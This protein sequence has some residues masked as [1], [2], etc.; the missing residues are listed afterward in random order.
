MIIDTHKDNLDYSRLNIYPDDFVSESKKQKSTWMKTTMD[1][2]ENVAL[3]QFNKNKKSI[4]NNYDLL[5]G[6]LKPQDFYMED[7]MEISSFMDQIVG[8]EGLPSHIKHYSILNPPLNSM[9]GELSKRPDYSKV[10]AFDD[11]SKNEELQAKTEILQQFIFQK[12]EQMVRQQLMGQEVEEEEIK[13]ITNE[14]IEEYLT[15]YTSLAERWS[16]HILEACKIEFN[17]KE[18]GEEAFRDFLISAREFH[19]IYED[20]SRLG[21]N[22]EILNPKNV[23]WLSTPDKK[24]IK[25]AYAAGTIHIMELSEIIERF[26]LTKEEIDHLRETLKELDIFGKTKSNLG[27]N[28][29]TGEDS[30]KYD[31]YSRALVEERLLAESVLQENED[32]LTVFGAASNIS[33]FGYKYRVV[34][35]YWIS[36]KKIAK[37]TY[38]D[39]EGIPQITLVDGDD[40]Q[41]IPNEIDVEFG[42]VNQWYRGLKIGNDIYYTS[43]LKWAEYCPII[44]VVHE[45]K[46]TEARSLVD[47][48]KPL[49]ILYN[50]CMNQ[51]FELLEK[52]IGVIGIVPIRRI[53]TPKDADGQDSLDLFEIEAKRKGLMYDDD[54]PENTKAPVSNTNVVKAVD[55]NRSAEIQARYQLAVTLKNE[56]WELVGFSRERLGGSMGSTQTATSI[57]NSVS[58]SYN[59]TEPYFVQHEYVM[60]QVYQALLDMAQFIESEKPTSTISY[61][62]STGEQSF[63]KINGSELKMRDLR[64]YV[65]S[66]AE[67]QKMFEE[68][69][70]LAQPM[71]Q[72]GASIYDVSVLY[73]TNSIRQMKDTFKKLKQKQEEMMKTQ[74]EM[75][76][77]KLQ[78]EQ[79]AIQAQLQAAA[80]E[81]ELNRQNENL[82]KE[83]DR[84]NKKEVAIISQL[85][86][87]P[88]ATADTDNSGVADALEITKMSA[89]RMQIERENQ[90]KMQELGM[91]GKE[92][93]NKVFLE[94]EKLKVERENMK[95]DE[96]IAKMQLQAAK[97]KAKTTSSKKKK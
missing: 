93:A 48:M 5:K 8:E 50:V 22:H 58:R 63:M 89:E 4:S 14:K 78:Q 91:K 51:L 24:Y 39:E 16:N 12:A 80:E 15:G 85:G 33:T 61:V 31:T 66:R 94:L 64:V 37:V 13:A 65:T 38:V 83:L 97:A 53:P 46:N 73:T 10:K 1:Y 90:M 68:L 92:Q 55:L 71:L 72:N 82:N 62:N 18:K 30:I 76:Q 49:Q 74:Q 81:A 29:P 75:E 52:E 70:Q 36:K 60:G 54:S 44:G 96:K 43:P 35:A 56:C 87:N 41:S 3:A 11:D 77:Q 47:L 32:P 2:F 26:N 40:Y 20:N 27:G 45:I 19:H 17:M 69:R 57:Q 21:F 34:Q 23:W 59:Q 79:E 86:R 25:D 84:L 28:G 6:I 9:V 7:S 42:Y 95:N 88:E 67:D